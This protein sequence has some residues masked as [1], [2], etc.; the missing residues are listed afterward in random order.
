M[1]RHD[2]KC[3][4]ECFIENQS[5]FASSIARP[6][7]SYDHRLSVGERWEHETDRARE[8]VL[9]SIGWVQRGHLKC[10]QSREENCKEEAV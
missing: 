9:I 3:F 5:S 7:L 1:H 4:D 10:V 2:V 6:S 8:R